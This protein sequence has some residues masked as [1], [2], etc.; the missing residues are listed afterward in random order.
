MKNYT[1]K[2]YIEIKDIN[3]LNRLRKILTYHKV[4]FTSNKKMLFIICISSC[5]EDFE[6]IHNWSYYKE[7]LKLIVKKKVIRWSY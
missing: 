2:F 5:Q 1:G 3:D 4:K 6:I 7:P